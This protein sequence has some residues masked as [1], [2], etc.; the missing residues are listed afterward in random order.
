MPPD[1]KLPDQVIIVAYNI[2]G[3]IRIHHAR[4]SPY[5]PQIW[6]TI[7]EACI[8]RVHVVLGLLNALNVHDNAAR[9]FSIGV[10]AFEKLSPYGVETP[11]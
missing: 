3:V 8:S 5:S 7:L 11:P 9:L 1:L 2:S 6:V 4:A 10:R